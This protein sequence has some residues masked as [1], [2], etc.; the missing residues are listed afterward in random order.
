[1][2]PSSEGKRIPEIDFRGISSRLTVS[3][4][5]M[6]FSVSPKREKTLGSLENKNLVFGCAG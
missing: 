4:T 3:L 2:K 1:M 5:P 6:D